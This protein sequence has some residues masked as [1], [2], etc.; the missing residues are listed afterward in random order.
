MTQEELYRI[1]YQWTGKLHNWTASEL[2]LEL[3]CE[4]FPDQYLFKVYAGSA[5]NYLTASGLPGFSRSWGE[6]SEEIRLLRPDD[7]PT[8]ADLDQLFK[9]ICLA[10]ARVLGVKIAKGRLKSGT[11]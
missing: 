7:N 1:Y 5:E 11:S 6:R 9:Q 2:E 10:A 3:D 8:Q 4:Y